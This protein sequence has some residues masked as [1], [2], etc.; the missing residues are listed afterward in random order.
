MPSRGTD[1]MLLGTRTATSPGRTCGITES[2]NKVSS[3]RIQASDGAGKRH[4]SGP[5][6]SLVAVEARCG[7][8]CH[9]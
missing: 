8:A 9:T 6:E 4:T 2:V 5:Q 7:V 1:A 3:G